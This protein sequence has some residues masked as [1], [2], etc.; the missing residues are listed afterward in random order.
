M[1][2]HTGILPAA[3]KAVEAL[4]VAL[5]P[6]IFAATANGAQVLITADHGNVEKMFDASAQQA[7]T[8]HTTDKVPLV[9][10]GSDAVTIRE[11]GALRDIAPT[12]L[13]MM[14]LTQ[15]AEMTGASLLML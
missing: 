9:Y 4:D 6:V 8:Q 1:V 14:G 15:P 12:L 2:G 3:I 10:V 11:G 5:A 7:H 13:A